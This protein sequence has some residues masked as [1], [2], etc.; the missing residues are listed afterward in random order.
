[1]IDQDSVN[2]ECYSIVDTKDES[3]PPKC[4]HD[5]LNMEG[6]CL[7]CGQDCRGIY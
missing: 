7:S 5:R 4:D 6:I 2:D 1:M 3:D